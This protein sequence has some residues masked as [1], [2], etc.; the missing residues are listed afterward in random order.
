MS[1][2]VASVAVLVFALIARRIFRNPW[3]RAVAITLFSFSFMQIAYAH[4][5]R[6]YAMMTML[7]AIDFYLVLLICDRSS[8]PR[9]VALIF[10][11]TISLYTNNM[12]AIYV[13]CL[14]GGWLILPGEGRF[15]DRLRELLIVGICV[16]VLFSPWVPVMLAQ[17]RRLRA[18][19]WP[20]RPDGWMLLR[21]IGVMTGAHEQAL[22]RG[23]GH[24]FS[25]VTLLLVTFAALG[26]Q[27]RKHWR[28]TAVTAVFGF[29]PILFIFFYSRSGTSIFV[30]RAFLASGIAMPLLLALALE[31]ARSLPARVVVVGGLAWVFYLHA[32]SLAG[33]FTGEQNE[34]WREASDYALRLSSAHEHTLTVFCSNECEVMYD[35]YA[36]HG[37]YS[38]RADL[39]GTPQ[40]FFELDPPRTL[41][42]VLRDQDVDKLRAAL[43]ARP[44]DSV[45]LIYSHSWWGDGQGRTLALI[46]S[47]FKLANAQQFKQIRV[48]WF[49]GRR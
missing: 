35:F 12:L 24:W 29:V 26:L 27:S 19:F 2:L 31:A 22:P 4:E 10:A 1:A 32:F 8:A 30:E 23:D 21:T 44:V 9:L 37:D 48:Y 39:V 13:A 40:G 18:G 17:T 16:A 33:R 43:D 42:R 49:S 25:Q 20:A 3:A 5:A 47:R 38:P 6:F 11:W 46:S 41:Q 7:G 34:S 36:R 15:K 45:V 28:L 14:G